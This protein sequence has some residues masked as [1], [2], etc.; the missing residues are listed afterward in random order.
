MF[1]R[2]KSVAA[3]FAFG[4]AALMAVGSRAAQTDPSLQIIS[5]R[6]PISFAKGGVKGSFYV[7]RA[8]SLFVTVGSDMLDRDKKPEKARIEIRDAT[9]T[10]TNLN[11]GARMQLL[12]LARDEVQRATAHMAGVCMER[13]GKTPAA[14]ATK[15]KVQPSIYRLAQIAG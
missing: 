15:R 3:F 12:P 8:G 13:K 1:N 9:A 7:T 5:C 10:I 4:L 11:S 14:P 6:S 2:K